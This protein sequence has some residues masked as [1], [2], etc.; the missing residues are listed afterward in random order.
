MWEVRPL[1]VALGLLCT[2]AHARGADRAA[3]DCPGPSARA[4]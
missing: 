1:V 2:F 4:T 3:R